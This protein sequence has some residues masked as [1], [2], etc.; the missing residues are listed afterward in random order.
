MG[1]RRT[2]GWALFAMVGGL[3]GLVTGWV[4]ETI[5]ESRESPTPTWTDSNPIDLD[6]VI[7]RTLATEPTTATHD[8]SDTPDESTEV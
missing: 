4:V 7:N 2:G 5:R 1:E 3:I 6:D 8:S